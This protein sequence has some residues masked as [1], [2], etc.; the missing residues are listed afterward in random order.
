MA[1]YWIV[2][3][4]ASQDKEAA[5]EYARLWNEISP[6]YGAKVIV[7]RGSHETMEGE[8]RP[9]NLIIEFPTYQDALDCYKDPDYTAAIEF[10]KKAFDRELVIIDGN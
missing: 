7:S 2:R 10:V 1:G 6:R 8:D 9:R 4:T 3:S 5:E